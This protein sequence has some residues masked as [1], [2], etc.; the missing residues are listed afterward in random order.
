MKL[1]FKNYTTKQHCIIALLLGIFY[2]NYWAEIGV[3]GATLVFLFVLPVAY[4]VTSKKT[5]KWFNK[6]F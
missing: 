5:M 2:M 6:V 1:N 3:A 4:I